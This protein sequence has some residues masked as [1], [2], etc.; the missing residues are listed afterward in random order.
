MNFKNE[1]GL[2]LIELIVAIVIIG[3]LAA[4]ATTTF[5]NFR[6]S[7]DSAAC[8]Q[9]QLHV[10]TANSFF[11]MDRYTDLS[12]V[13]R[14]ANTL[15]ELVPYFPSGST[16]ECPTGGTYELDSDGRCNCTEATHSRF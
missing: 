4:A 14:Y 10:E 16:I 8:K 1:K 13:P 11:Y 6:D 9:N 5:Q 3:V 7:A 2:T 15:T 12:E